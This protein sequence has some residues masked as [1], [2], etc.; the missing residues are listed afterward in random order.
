MESAI[1]VALVAVTLGAIAFGLTLVRRPRDAAVGR[2][3]LERTRAIAIVTGGA[4][5]LAL[6]A[7]IGRI[8]GRSIDPVLGPI[9]FAVAGAIVTLG[10]GALLGWAEVIARQDARFDDAADS[11]GSDAVRRTGRVA[12]TLGLA[13]AA[14]GAVALFLA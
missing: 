11:T 10:G 4:I 3:L 2:D 8:V 7:S 1:V 5:V 13:V 9:G 14:I 6:V 12:V